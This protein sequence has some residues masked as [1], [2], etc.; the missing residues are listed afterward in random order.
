MW[1]KYGA[2][3]R[4]A[5]WVTKATNTPSECITLF[6]FP[7]QRWLHEHISMI[8][9][10]APSLSCYIQKE[11]LGNNITANIGHHTSFIDYRK[12]VQTDIH[13]NY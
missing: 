8:R 1:E 11:L 3:M 5:C 7:W 6:V 13:V 2:A 10:Y 12:T 4:N 9:S